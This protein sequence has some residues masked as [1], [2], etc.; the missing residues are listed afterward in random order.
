LSEDKKLENKSLTVS[1]SKIKTYKQCPRRYYYSYIAKYPKKDWDHF[2]LGTFVHGV[3]EFFHGQFKEDIADFNFK[4]LMKESFKK[5]KDIMDADKPIS[6]EIL[7]EARKLLTEYLKSM[8]E[9]GLGSKI[10]TLEE[11]FVI[12]LNE[13]YKLKG[14]IDRTDQDK[15]GVYHIKD[16]KTNKDT[17]Y[18]EYDQLRAYG[19]YLVNQYPE[20]KNFRGS[21]IMLRFGGMYLKYEFNLEDVEKAKKDLIVYA[22][23]IC[24]DER[25]ISKPSKLCDWCDFKNICYNTWN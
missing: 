17:K 11:E 23:K 21:Y 10:L 1:I 20:V 6:K 3:L 13:K 8:E 14:I 16:Y 5:Q 18:M 22:D 15:D 7:D 12:D 19:L 2:T 9:K 24:E 4:K 25:W